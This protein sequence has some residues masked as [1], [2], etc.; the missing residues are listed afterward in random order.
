MASVHAN[1]I[2][3]S[4]DLRGPAEAPV[5]MMSHSLMANR[6]MWDPQMPALS[7]YR[8][9]RYDTRGHGGSTAPEGAYTLELLA[10]DA[11]ALMRAL[12]IAKVHWVGLSMGGMIGQTIAIHHPE[13]L[14]SLTLADT[15]SGYPPEM[16]AMWPDRIANAHRTGIPAMAEGTLDRWFSPA[17]AK[18]DP[19]TIGKVKDMICATPLTGYVGCCHAISGLDAT[20][21]L[22]TVTAPTLIVV[23]EDDP[24]TP[25]A[26][27]QILHDR[28]A[29]SELVILPGARH[30]ANMEDPAGFDAAL[31]RFLAAH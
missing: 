5:V 17:F 2:D 25:V 10:E 14:L 6:T 29:G 3:I 1:G 8:V 16:K 7:A 15:S 30:L 20:G 19:A 4:Y 26:M 24:G 28:I 31:T 21:R 13:V 18:R 12:G 11:V 22:G 23:G 27:S 9:L